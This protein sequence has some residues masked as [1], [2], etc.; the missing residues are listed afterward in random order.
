ME[1]SHFLERQI[2]G[3]QFFFD[4]SKFFVASVSFIELLP[5]ALLKS[6]S[7]YYLSYCYY[8]NIKG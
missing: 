6:V 3:N 8:V 4:V 5:F 7:S 1:S 2:N